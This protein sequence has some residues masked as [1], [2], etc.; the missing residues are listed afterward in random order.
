MQTLKQAL[1]SRTWKHDTYLISTDS[2]MIPISELNA[3]FAT[4]LVYWADPLPEEIMR[5]TLN[6]SLCFGLYDIQTQAD[7]HGSRA[8]SSTM[9]VKLIGFA[10]CVTDFTTFSYLTDVYVLPSY[11]G[12]GLGR[13]I[14]ACVDEVHGS[15]PHLR[16]SML[17]TSDWKR[18]VPLYE[19]VLGMETIN[20]KPEESG[21]PAI[22][23]KLG[24]GFPASLKRS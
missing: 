19:S 24:P 8:E 15:M 23:Q 11:Q 17:F 16:R 5:E 6:N 9:G 2:S 1:L 4:D 13:W 10:R 22:M 20:G 18:S 14:A 7:V 21:G 12:G 3:V